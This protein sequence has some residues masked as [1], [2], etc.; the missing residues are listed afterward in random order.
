[1][2]TVR[3]ARTF[4]LSIT[5]DTQILS[6]TDVDNNVLDIPNIK[7]IRCTSTVL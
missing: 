4:H 2:F 1:V 5:K 7:V 3:S 6:C